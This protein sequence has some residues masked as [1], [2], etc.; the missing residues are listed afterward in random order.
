LNGAKNQAAAR[1]LA[2]WSASHKANELYSRYLAM[3]AIEGVSSTIAE[4]PKGVAETMIKNDFAWAAVE[5]PRILAEWQRRYH[6]KQDK[7]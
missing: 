2:D 5:R 6:E 7:R 1:R 4:Y 3:V